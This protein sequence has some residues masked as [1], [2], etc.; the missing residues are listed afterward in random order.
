MIT[1]DTILDYLDDIRAHPEKYVTLGEI[2]TSAVHLQAL[3]RAPTLEA[4]ARAFQAPARAAKAANDTE[5]L[6]ML[7]SAKDERKAALSK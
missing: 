3:K 2:V 4:L 7:T 1:R 5:L 6:A